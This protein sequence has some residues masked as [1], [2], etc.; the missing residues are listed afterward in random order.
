MRTNFFQLLTQKSLDPQKEYETLWYLFFEE[1]SVV[2]YYS[3]VKTLA[4]YIDDKYFRNLPFRGTFASL[5]DMMEAVDLSKRSAVDI[6][7]LFIFCELLFAVMFDRMA[8]EY[9][10]P[11]RDQRMTILGNINHILEKTNHE[12]QKDADG[13]FIIVEKNK[14]ATMAAQLVTDTVVAFDLIEYN[15][16]A[17]KGHLAEKQKILAS[18]A[19]YIEPILNSKALS[20]AGYKQLESDAGFVFN[21]FHI[22]HNNKEGKKANDYIASIRDTDLEAWYDK[23]YELAL[24]VII[25]N[26]YLSIGNDI[27]EIKP[28]YTWRT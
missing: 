15:H 11:M 24:S 17:I 10:H 16:F 25:I 27:A 5:N 18:I 2:A 20:D 19:S 22:R 9:V 8:N 28:K 23:A 26:D 12:F 3:S 21:N 7:K 13:N 14:A 6:D 4:K 1:R